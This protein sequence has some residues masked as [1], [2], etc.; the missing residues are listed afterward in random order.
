MDAGSECQA[1][2]STPSSAILPFGERTSAG[3]DR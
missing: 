2:A 3:I 1:R